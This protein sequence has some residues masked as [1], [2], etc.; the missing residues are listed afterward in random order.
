MPSKQTG[1]CTQILRSSSE[2]D[3][4]LVF[5]AVLAEDNAGGLLQEGSVEL[6]E[7]RAQAKHHVRQFLAATHQPSGVAFE[8]FLEG[9]VIDPL[10]ES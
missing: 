8:R 4:Q 1:S 9:A 6:G 3:V 7:S 2:T 5:F 10:K